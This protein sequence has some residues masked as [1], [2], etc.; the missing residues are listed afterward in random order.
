MLIS[1]P[2]SR[3][4]FIL[5]TGGLTLGGGLHQLLTS[6]AQTVSRSSP[7]SSAN[8]LSSIR[9]PDVEIDLKAVI[10][11]VKILPGQSTQVW[12]YQARL[13][14]GDAA[15]LQVLPNSYLGPTIRVHQGQR[16]RIHFDNALPGNQP[17]I[18]HWHGLIVP[19]AMDGHPQQAIAPGERYTYEFDVVN[20]AGSNW[21]HAHPHQLTG[22][23]V[24][25]GLAGLFLVADDEESKLNLPTGD[26]DLPIVLQDRSFDRQNQLLYLGFQNRAQQ[27]RAGIPGMM[28]GMGPMMN[29]GRNPNAGMGG[30]MG[31]MMGFLGDKILV[32]GHWN[33]PL[34]VATRIYRL[35]VFNASNARIYKLAWSHGEPLTAIATDGHLLPKPIQRPYVLLAPG[36]RVDLWADFSK[37]KVGTEVFLNSLEFSGAETFGMGGMMQGVQG[38]N[39]NVP[40]MGAAMTLLKIRVDRQE[41]ESLTLPNILTQAPRLQ[42]SEAVN[43]NNPRQIKINSSGMQWLLNNKTFEMDTVAEDEIVKLNTIEQWM[44]INTANMNLN[45]SPNQQQFRMNAMGMA[46]SMAHPIH[47]HG[48][49]FQVIDRQV[50]PDGQAAWQTVKAGY[51]DDGWKDTVMV[52]P[53][54]QVKLLMKFVHY[55]GRSMYHCHNLEHEDGGMM[56][57][58]QIT[59]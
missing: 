17:S 42:P 49:Q 48:V 52:M 44:I 26:Y 29:R 55:S 50:L 35:R 13:V 31:H 43:V 58:Y 59:T 21:F 9:I 11:S 20:P 24:Y 19:E 2:I 38:I 40:G 10:D 34:N 12:T 23:Q 14:K 53:G 7:P 36:E 4:R 6:C 15:S 25:R 32:N 1:R 47:I 41:K 30:M 51:I 54:E 27:G 28:P 57:N 5:T 37:L 56:R 3:R 18:I 16:V 33:E 46:H 45:R 22:E 8:L 39:G